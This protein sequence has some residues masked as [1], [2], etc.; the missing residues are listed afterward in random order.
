[1]TRG[2]KGTCRHL[3]AKRHCLDRHVD[4]TRRISVDTYVLLDLCV[5]FSM[6][7][8]THNVYMNVTFMC[9]VSTYFI[10]MGMA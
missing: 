4:L 7:S 10:G 9:Y 1:M 5:W 3:C 6:T 8:R 2:K